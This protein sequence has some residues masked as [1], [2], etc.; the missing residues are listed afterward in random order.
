MQIDLRKSFS[1]DAK[2]CTQ[3]V[4]EAIAKAIGEM[5]SAASLTELNNVKAMKG[6]KAARDAYRMCAKPDLRL[7]WNQRAN[8]FKK[9]VIFWKV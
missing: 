8:R 6:S 5:T 4:K 9:S 3:T 2:K 7:H 1:R